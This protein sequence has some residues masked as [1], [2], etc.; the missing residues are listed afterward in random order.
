M[1]HFGVSVCVCGFT[2]DQK[3]SDSGFY[4]ANEVKKSAAFGPLLL[5]PPRRDIC[6]ACVCVFRLLFSSP[7]T[8]AAARLAAAVLAG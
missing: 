3:R 5:P 1:M 6:R 2:V 8:A 4:E 7:E